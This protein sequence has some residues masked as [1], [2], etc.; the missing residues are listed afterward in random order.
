MR[1]FNN[2]SFDN[3]TPE[4][5]SRRKYCRRSS[6]GTGLVIMANSNVEVFDNSF[7]NNSTIHI[8]VVSGDLESGDE[9][10]YP[11]PKSIQIHNNSYSNVGY[12]P[13]VDRGFK[14]IVSGN[15]RR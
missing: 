13:D 3:N 9:N 14:Q 11:H 12:S 4:F 2:R 10:Y 6:S 15:Y 7:S 5:C 8:A 1:V